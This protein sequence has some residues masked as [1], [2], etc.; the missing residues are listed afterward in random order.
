MLRR[1]KTPEAE[2]TVTF[3]YLFFMSGMYILQYFIVIQ[4]KSNGG[5]FRL[6]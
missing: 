1:V 6:G 3:N 5:G 4:G 2:D